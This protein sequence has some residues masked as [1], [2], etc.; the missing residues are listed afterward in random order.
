MVVRT[1]MYTGEWVV[2]VFVYN[3]LVIKC[4]FLLV[5]EEGINDNIAKRFT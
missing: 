1:Y 2:A 4:G 3:I 5:F